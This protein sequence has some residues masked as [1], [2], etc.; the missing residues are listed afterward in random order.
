MRAEI[1]L[2]WLF[3]GSGADL[4]A[5]TGADECGTG[6]DLPACAGA[7]QCGTGAVDSL[8]QQELLLF[9]SNDVPD[10]ALKQA[11][12]DSPPAVDVEGGGTAKAEQ[13]EVD[14]ESGMSTK[15]MVA[16]AKQARQVKSMMLK[17]YNESEARIR[18][19]H[20]ALSKRLSQQEAGNTA[21]QRQL[22]DLRNRLVQQEVVLT[23][24][25]EQLD[26]KQHLNE[27]MRGYFRTMRP[28]VASAQQ[29]IA[30]SKELC[31]LDYSAPEMRTIANEAE[32]DIVLGLLQVKDEPHVGLAAAASAMAAGVELHSRSIQEAEA[33]HRQELRDQFDKLSKAVKDDYANMTVV[34]KG[35]QMNLENVAKRGNETAA[36]ITDADKLAQELK[37]YMAAFLTFV[38]KVDIMS[39]WANDTVGTSSSTDNDA[40]G[41]SSST[42]P[43]TTVQNSTDPSATSALQILRGVT[44]R[45]RAHH[46]SWP[47]SPHVEHKLE[48][49]VLDGE[50]ES[51]KFEDTMS[52]IEQTVAQQRTQATKDMIEEERN[53]SAQLA[54]LDAKARKD[55]AA[56][57]ALVETVKQYEKFT[58]ATHG[59]INALL[60]MLTS[61]C[62]N[63]NLLQPRVEAA[64]K[65]IDK[66]LD[67]TR[68]DKRKVLGELQLQVT[69][70]EETHTAQAPAALVQLADP[71]DDVGKEL[72]SGLQGSIEQ[73][74]DEF[75]YQRKEMSDKFVAEAKVRE[76]RDSK[77][78][79]QH[80]LLE[81]QR[82][83]LQERFAALRKTKKYLEHR[84][85][86]FDPL[87][88]RLAAFAADARAAS[89]L[90]EPEE[91]ADEHQGHQQD[92]TLLDTAQPAVSPPQ[93]QGEDHKDEGS[94]WKALFGF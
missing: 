20:D 83:T 59:E 27:A 16:F 81:E 93:G 2:W 39:N 12:E 74:S 78:L 9:R 36:S 86:E 44:R 47:G 89:N 82:A 6:A 51:Q 70:A 29:D 67:E 13:L 23:T 48:M 40:V 60:E 52:K 25:K 65:F 91:S 77:L 31:A 10:A 58:K 15:A 26:Q 92:A 64:M 38:D 18:A 75:V 24:A 87:R 35:L 1:F 30:S 85:L 46:R 80:K 49:P 69:G 66:M 45:H 88:Q 4:P 33:K 7:D 28:R 3:A 62:R 34:E 57:E 32:P 5:C 90:R 54:T 11:S 56:N 22:D 73:M 14:S 84:L 43:T 37:A 72:L 55:E 50:S 8:L 21:K 76:D 61:R 41:T 68:G 94:I 71:S 63:L 79:A 53:F 17:R 19:E 42:G